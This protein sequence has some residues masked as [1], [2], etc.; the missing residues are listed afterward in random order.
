MPVTAY[1]EV[2]VWFL[3]VQ[4]QAH[5]LKLLFKQ[6]SGRN[7]YLHISRFTF[8]C[9]KVNSTICLLDTHTITTE[10][11]TIRVWSIMYVQL[12]RKCLNSFHKLKDISMNKICFLKNKIWGNIICLCF[13]ESLA[14]ITHSCS[15]SF[16]KFYIHLIQSVP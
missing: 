9:V 6:F 16:L 2:N 4:S 7:N 5:R 13:L 15:L 10:N 1:L 3:F 12:I 14:I 8:A 11:K